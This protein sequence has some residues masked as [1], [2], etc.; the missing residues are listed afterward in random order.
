MRGRSHIDPPDCLRGPVCA[1]A[2]VLPRRQGPKLKCCVRNLV[3]PLTLDSYPGACGGELKTLRCHAKLRHVLLQTWVVFEAT[4][5]PGDNARDQYMTR[6]ATVKPLRKQLPDENGD[7]AETPTRQDRK[8]RH[9]Y[10]L[11]ADFATSTKKG[12]PP[13]LPEMSDSKAKLDTC[14]TFFK[15]KRY[16][17]P[18][19][20]SLRSHVLWTSGNRSGGGAKC[21]FQEWT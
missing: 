13:T 5:K 6:R 15:S 16:C 19:S 4:E 9:D 10:P 14:R 18:N 20:K 17:L 7:H 8:A 12:K 2:G 1:G 3:R 11:L 21:M